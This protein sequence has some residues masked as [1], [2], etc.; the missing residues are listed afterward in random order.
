MPSI[1][2]PYKADTIEELAVRLG[3]DP[4]KVAATVVGFN[5]ACR[6]GAFDHTIHDDCRTEGLTV[7]KTQPELEQV[8]G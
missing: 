4:G 6:P 3:L 1:F 7:E 2:Q 5:T 8:V